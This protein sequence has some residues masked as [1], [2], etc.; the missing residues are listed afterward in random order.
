MV[1]EEGQF[2]R[3]SDDDWRS[4]PEPIPDVM[5]Y[6]P[7]PA[8]AANR[9]E[10]MQD[11]SN[12]RSVQE[13]LNVGAYEALEEETMDMVLSPWEKLS[14]SNDMNT[15]NTTNTDE[16]SR[17]E[18]PSSMAGDDVDDPTELRRV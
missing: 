2:D 14:I 7:A 8:L 9:Q 16:P 4:P 13:V 12:S 15:T 10:P 17:S 3:D 1:E 18:G 11:N 5:E 6:T